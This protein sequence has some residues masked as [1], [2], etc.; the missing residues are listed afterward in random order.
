[1]REEQQSLH[2][3][4][5]RS[6]SR[7]LRFSKTINCFRKGPLRSLFDCELLLN[8]IPFKQGCQ[9]FKSGSEGQAAAAKQ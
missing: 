3:V 1:M 8:T 2:S 6:S 5:K 9:S 7:N 4:Y